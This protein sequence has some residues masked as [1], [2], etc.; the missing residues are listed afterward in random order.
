MNDI[1]PVIEL[2]VK[3]RAEQLDQLAFADLPD[4]DKWEMLF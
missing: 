1:E 2:K 3:L 4:L